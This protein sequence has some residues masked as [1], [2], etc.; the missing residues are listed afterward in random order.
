MAILKVARLGHPVLRQ[1]AQPL[2]PASIRSP[3][4]QR[5]IDDM[6]ETMRE[7]DGAGLAATQVHTLQQIAVDTVT[8][9][10][11][12]PYLIE[13]EDNFKLYVFANRGQESRPRD[14]AFVSAIYS[15]GTWVW[16][17]PNMQYEAIAAHGIVDAVAAAWDPV[18]NLVVVVNDHSGTPSYLAFTLDVND[19]KRSFNTPKFVIANND[20]GTVIVDPVTGDYYL[21][22]METIHDTVNGRACY[23]RWNGTAWSDFVVLDQSSADVAFQVR[24]GGGPVKDFIFGRG[25]DSGTVQIHY[26]RIA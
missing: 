17:S 12:Y 22:F 10:P 26:A 5:F 20:W 2:D 8:T 18:H 21:L 11:F 16:R 4:V 1:V 23:T 13:R 3:A 25:F 19:V 15:G 7:Y 9:E 6:I 24:S 14:M